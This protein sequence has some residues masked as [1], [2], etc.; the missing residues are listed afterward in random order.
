[1]A[2]SSGTSKNTSDEGIQTSTN[3]TVAT[4]IISLRTLPLPQL[5]TPPLTPPI[6]QR[7]PNASVRPSTSTLNPNIYQNILTVTLF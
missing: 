1:M 6:T 5:S 2:S 3:T 7:L 4:P